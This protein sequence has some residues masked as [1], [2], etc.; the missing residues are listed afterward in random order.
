MAAQQAGDLQAPTD[1]KLTL[2]LDGR[3]VTPLV[4]EAA[5]AAGARR[6]P[7]SAA[8][9]TVAGDARDCQLVAAGCQLLER[10]GL[11]RTS[12]AASVASAG[13]VDATAGWV[14]SMARM[15]AFTAP[16]PCPVTIRTEMVP[17]ARS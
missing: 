5:S 10:G 6:A 12:V 4:W 15:A 17:R 13:S 1:V 9:R 3:V 2:I 14:R 8:T 16:V 7:G 11:S